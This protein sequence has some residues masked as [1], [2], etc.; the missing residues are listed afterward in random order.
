MTKNG[1][2]ETS[3]FALRVITIPLQGM[4]PNFH[5]HISQS[6]QVYQRLREYHR[7]GYGAMEIRDNTKSKGTSKQS[8]ISYI[9]TAA[10]SSVGYS[11][12][13]TPEG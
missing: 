1:R 10:F 6:I 8:K 7:R 3:G 12:N 9:L 2:L 4:V 13:T 5:S 11:K